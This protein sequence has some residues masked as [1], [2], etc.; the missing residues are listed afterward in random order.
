DRD[1]HV[2]DRDAA[3][4]ARLYEI[5]CLERRRRLVVQDALRRAVGVD[6]GYLEHHL[7]ETPQVTVIVVVV[8]SD[9]LG[10]DDQQLVGVGH[11]ALAGKLLG[12]AQER[13]W[14][15]WQPLLV[16]FELGFF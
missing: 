2:G 16:G 13:I 1:Q 15:L 3:G 10:R 8:L 9:K 6:I 4:L 14:Q 5:G 11:I 12:G 7:R